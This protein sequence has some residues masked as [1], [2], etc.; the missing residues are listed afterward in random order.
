M[1]EA[2]RPSSMMFSGLFRITQMNRGRSLAPAS[3]DA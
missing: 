3:M 2:I 1:A